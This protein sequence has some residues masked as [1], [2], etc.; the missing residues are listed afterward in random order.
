M[1]GDHFARAGTGHHLHL[2]RRCRGNVVAALHARDSPG[3]AWNKVRAPRVQRHR[4]PAGIVDRR[5][6][7]GGHDLEARIVVIVGGVV[8]NFHACLANGRAELQELE[9]GAIVVATGSKPYLPDAF[10]YG[11]LRHTP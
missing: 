4:R 7:L 3:T 11:F 9:I 5:A 10:G 1:T 2:D 6:V 8:G